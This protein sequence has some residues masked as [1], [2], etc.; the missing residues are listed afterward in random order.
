VNLYTERGNV[1]LLELAS[2]VTL[3]EGGLNVGNNVSLAMI[4]VGAPGRSEVPTHEK[5]YLASTTITDQNE[6]EAGNVSCCFSH[7][8]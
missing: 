2:Q 6:L 8:E 1:F 3:D 5:P 7:G 4:I